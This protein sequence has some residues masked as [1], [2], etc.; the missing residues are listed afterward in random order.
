MLD[1]LCDL[2]DKHST[3]TINITDIDSNDDDDKSTGECCI[4]DLL[5]KEV[6]EDELADEFGPICLFIYSYLYQVSSYD[7]FWC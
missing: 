7:T 4:L 6:E 1:Q 3:N 2:P 5:I